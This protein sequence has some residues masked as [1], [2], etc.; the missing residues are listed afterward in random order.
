MAIASSYLIC[1]LWK[2]EFQIVHIRLPALV[3][4]ILNIVD[5]VRTVKVLHSTSASVYGMCI[6]VY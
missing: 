4:S 3:S 5:T 2:T 1:V 6:S